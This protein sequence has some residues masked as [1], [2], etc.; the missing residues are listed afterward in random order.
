MNEATGTFPDWIASRAAATPGR[1]ALI[2]GEQIWTFASLDEEVT[3][4]AR[5]LAGLG[6]MAGDRITTLLHNGAVAAILPHASLRLGATLVPL[7]VRLTESEIAWQIRDASPR[8]IVVEAS[9]LGCLESTR[10]SNP[11]LTVVS[12]TEDPA[13]DLNTHAFGE[14]LEKDIELRLDHPADAVL[15]VIYTSGTTGT[16]KGTMLTVSNF[17]WNAIGSA[18]NLGLSENDR[19]LVCLPLFHVGGLSIITRSAIYGTTAIV[20]SGFDAVAVNRAIDNDGVSIVSVVSV[21]LQRMLDARGDN[22]YPSTLR[23]VLLGGGPTPKVL[24]D[25]CAHSGVPV[26]QTY[27]LTESCS[28]AVTL[29]PDDALSRLGSVGKAL[30]PNQVRVVTSDGSDATTDEAGEILV[31]GPVVMLGYFGQAEATSRAMD[32]GWL[33]TGDIGRFDADGYLYVL[34]RRDDLIVTGGENVYPAEVEAVLQ[35]HPSIVESAVIGADDAEWGQRVVAIARLDD[36]ADLAGIDAGS[37]Q[38]FCRERLAGYKVPREFRFTTEPLPRTASGK[39]R[40]A[41]LRGDRSTR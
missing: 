15:A 2:S 17:W 31:R 10:D 28:Q 26:V 4:T 30:Y 19:W 1:I 21:M 22:P 39:L 38:L 33:H 34:D 11:K 37:L 14:C 25:R 36:T 8:L 5:R 24:L 40:R 12:I 20:H 7:N 27:G 13:Q 16:P 23:C 32:D 41:V 3:R 9:T 29:A 18:L 6:V 35:A